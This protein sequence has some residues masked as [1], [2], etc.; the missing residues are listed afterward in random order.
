MFYLLLLF[1]KGIKPAWEDD[2]NK[3]R[4]VCALSAELSSSKIIDDIWENTVSSCLGAV[5]YS[6]TSLTCIVIVQSS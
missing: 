6:E 1:K 4:L 5:F 3:S 2:E